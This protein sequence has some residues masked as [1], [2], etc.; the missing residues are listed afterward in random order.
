MPNTQRIT[1]S[2]PNDIIEQIEQLKKEKFSNLSYAEL[3]RQ[4]I[5][6]GI[7]TLE[8]KKAAKK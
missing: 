6:A 3:Y 5:G 2:L 7:Q 8:N 4:A 1:V